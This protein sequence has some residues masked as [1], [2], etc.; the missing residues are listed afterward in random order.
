MKFLVS[1]LSILL[2]TTLFAQNLAPDIANYD[3]AVSLDTK[4]KVL[5]GT[6]KLTWT[7]TSP[8]AINE[9]QFHLYLNAFRDKKSTMMKESRG[10]LHGEVFNEKGSGNIYITS[11]KSN[12]GEEFLNKLKYIQPDDN[13]E[14]DRTV[15]SIPLKM[16]LGPGQT[17]EIDL[18]FKAKL[19][20]IFARTGFGENDYYLIGQWFPK[21]GVFEEN[22]AGDWAWNCH[23]FHPNTEFYA[24]FGKYKVSITLP[25]NLTVGAT[26]KKTNSIKLKGS[27]KTEVFEIDDVH[28]FAWTASPHFKVYE[29]NW[30]HV[31]ITAL[32]QPEHASQY[33]RYFDGAEKALAYFEK[34]LGKYP[35]ETLTLVDPPLESSGS[36]GMEYPTFV[37]CGSYWGVGKWF[38]FAEIVTVH[39]FGHQ[40]FQGILASNEFEQSFLD[41]GFNQ[42]MEGRIMD[43]GYGRGS[44]FDLFGF[45]LNDKETAR[46]SYVGMEYPELSEI[47]KPSW[48]YPRGVY[49]ELS[50]SKTATILH[51]FERMIG[52]AQMDKILK[53]YYEKWKYKHPKLK[54][55][56]DV[57]NQTLG[58]NY[59]WYF[60]QAFEKSY[61]CDYS[62][63]TLI[64][65]A[66][67]SSFTLKRKGKFILPQEVLVSFGDGSSELFTWD[68]KTTMKVFNYSKRIASVQ[69]DPQQKNLLDLNL[70]NNS[71]SDS[72][73][74]TFLAKYS[75][76]AI[77]WMQH[78]VTGF[79][80]WIG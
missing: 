1:L 53:T 74:N 79:L 10:I 58:K 40:Y 4:D 67:K 42:Y 23:Q 15:I 75:A 28:D 38:K 19:P 48:T 41:E 49:G 61:S 6:E 21:I 80:Y 5:L 69:I 37:T 11:L 64:N 14:N 27:L 36:G 54:D 59:D 18:S 33:K 12:R 2:S 77:F 72:N 62:V 16:P 43:E 51:T 52:T 22:N 9:L 44:Y 65:S 24:D 63:D 73:P 46:Y 56:E 70:L 7:N 20:K 17:I 8:M 78:F 50:Y 57:A 39:E 35:Y 34:T 32:M 13:N 45:V 71:L 3:I 55:F 68:A 66:S 29:K 31:K 60:E 26:G 76:K 25:E 47:N 30:K